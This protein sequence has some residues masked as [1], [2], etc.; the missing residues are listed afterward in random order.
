MI[1]MMLLMLMLVAGRRMWRR[2][3]VYL[4]LSKR[5]AVLRDQRVL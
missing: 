2:L 3:Q 4:Q 1:V 5:R